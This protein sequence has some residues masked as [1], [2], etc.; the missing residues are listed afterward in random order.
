MLCR[1]VADAVCSVMDAMVGGYVE[2]RW[3]YAVPLYH[4]LTGTVKP[5]AKTPEKSSA[6][7]REPDWW[8][9]ADFV[10]VVERFKVLRK[11]NM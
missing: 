11:E 10:N 7:H 9:I 8:G 1:E 3:L 4:F 5:F 2:Y 6:S